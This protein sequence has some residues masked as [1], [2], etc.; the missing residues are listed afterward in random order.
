LRDGSSDG[1]RIKRTRSE[2]LNELVVLTEEGEIWKLQSRKSKHKK[3]QEHERAKVQVH[4]SSIVMRNHDPAAG[5]CNG[6]P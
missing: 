4:V 1:E 5:W 3:S 2:R 6:A